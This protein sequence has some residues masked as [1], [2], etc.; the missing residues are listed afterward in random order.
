[1]LDNSVIENPTGV[2]EFFCVPFSD[3]KLYP[4]DEEMSRLMITLMFES[5]KGADS[6]Q[7][8]EK[9]KPFILKLVEGALKTRFTFTINDNGLVFFIAI[10]SKNA[11]TAIMY[12]AY[13]QYRCK[14]LNKR[15]L[16][17]ELFTSIFPNGFPNETDLH[18]IWDAQKVKRHN[19]DSFGS[20]NLLDYQ[21]AMK[22]I[23]FLPQEAP[24]N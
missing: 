3:L 12:L 22:S 24:I 6:L 18:N 20:D 2:E 9:E 17:W 5:K 11:G 16:D 1:M 23:Q 15:N 10:Q 21:S 8:P 19:T 7:I 13:L 14:K 4:M